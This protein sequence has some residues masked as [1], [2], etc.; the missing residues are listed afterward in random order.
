MP[1]VL[2]QA[3][4]PVIQPA[5][6]PGAGD[7]GLAPPPVSVEARRI[8]SAILDVL[9]GVRSITE[10]AQALGITTARYYAWESRAVTALVAACEPRNPGPVPGAALPAEIER[11]R[12]ERDRL[13]AEAARYQALARIAQAAFGPPP[14]P[15]A[16]VASGGGGTADR[17]GARQ[18]RARTAAPGAVPNAATGPKPRQRKRPAV[19]ALR[20]ARQVRDAGGTAAPAPPAHATPP[21]AISPAS[22]AG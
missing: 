9:A 21:P 4:D 7:S 12:A 10:A 8:A 14:S 11:L 22:V 6:Q 16:P 5:D 2:P 18:R 15:A 3:P 1:A 17:P 19:R 13:K 20:L